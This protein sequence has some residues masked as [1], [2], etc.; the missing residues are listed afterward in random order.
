MRQ[1]HQVARRLC[2]ELD[3]QFGVAQNYT[4]GIRASRK[5]YT[6]TAL[7]TLMKHPGV[8]NIRILFCAGLVLRRLFLSAG[9]WV[10]GNRGWLLRRWGVLGGRWLAFLWLIFRLARLLI[11]ILAMTDA[12]TAGAGAAATL[13]VASAFR[14]TDILQVLLN[15]AD[16]Y[17]WAGGGDVL[18]IF[19]ATCC[20]YLHLFALFCLR[21]RGWTF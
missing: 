1:R 11:S 6:S 17:A 2:R 16:A 9:L 20:S 4:A 10:A 7:H 13:G 18:S 15:W 19:G 21:F 14:R 8:R 3:T 5:G 12:A